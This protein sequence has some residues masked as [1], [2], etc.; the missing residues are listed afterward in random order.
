MRELRPLLEGAGYSVL[1]LDEAGLYEEPIEDGLEC[2][3]SFEEN[4]VAKA[5]HF[6]ARSGV[7]VMADDSGLEVL[8]LSGRPGVLSKRWSGR[9]DLSGE[10]LDEANNQR[11]IT[12][13]E[14]VPDRRARYVC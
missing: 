7:P 13:L 1:S 2:F 4:A 6:R 9:T 5:R 10:A 3:D 14:A 8:A 11:L 12:Q